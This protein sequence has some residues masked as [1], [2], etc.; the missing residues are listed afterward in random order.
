M[1]VTPKNECGQGPK[2]KLKDLKAFKTAQRT[3]P[4][5]VLS[6]SEGWPFKMHQKFRCELLTVIDHPFVV[7][8]E[9]R[10]R[11]YCVETYSPLTAGTLEEMSKFCKSEGFNFRIDPRFGHWNPGS[12][13]C[14]VFWKK[15]K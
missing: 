8:T 13:T 5:P 7:M 11:L 3:I 6:A 14:I 15:E 9:D 1:E 10:Q 2:R 12:C 4:Y